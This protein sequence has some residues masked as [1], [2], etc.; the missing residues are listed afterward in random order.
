[1]SWTILEHGQCDMCH[2]VLI[3][4]DLWPGPNLKGAKTWKHDFELG[5]LDDRD[6]QFA[7][8]ILKVLNI[9]IAQLFFDFAITYDNFI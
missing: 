1:M 9:E 8:S 7:V 2:F 5:R 6:S 3:A 4:S